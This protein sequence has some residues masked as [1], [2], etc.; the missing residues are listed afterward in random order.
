MTVSPRPSAAASGLQVQAMLLATTAVWGVNLS[1]VKALT[2][3]LD[4]VVVAAVRMVVA[5]LALSVMLWPQR[6]AMAL[7]SGRQL[8]ALGLCAV[9][10][11]Y[12]NQILFASA[13]AHTSATSAAIVMAL[14]P[15]AS[16]VVAA[17]LLREGL[18]WRRLAGIAI[19]FAGVAVIVLNRRSASLAGH[20]TGDLLMLA[21]ILC[22]ATGGAMVQRLSGG[23]SAVQISWAV[24]VV[25]AAMLCA[26]AAIGPAAVVQ[27][28]SGASATT[29]GLIVFSGV[30]ATA[31]AAIAWNRAIRRIGIA[32]TALA[33]YWVPVFGLA[34]AAFAFDEPVTGLHGI[35]LACVVA[36]SVVAM[37]R[38]GAAP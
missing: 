19:G 22:F 9:L 35:G 18:G 7:L 4:I 31:L 20:W 5:V 32:R 12:G 30:G 25:G 13:L 21:S 33:F 37:R 28:L 38:Q 24:H 2:E 14:S 34:F 8:G 3:T 36:G 6:R 29:W 1:A 10:M 11:V 23:L 17:L 15:L 26:H 16:S 27:P